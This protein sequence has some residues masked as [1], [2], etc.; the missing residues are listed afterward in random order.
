MTPTNMDEA[1]ASI[2]SI[3]NTTSNVLQTASAL[4]GTTDPFLSD[5]TAP[6]EPSGHETALEKE[7]AGVELEGGGSSTGQ[8]KE[9]SETA[10]VLDE[11]PSSPP[12]ASHDALKETLHDAAEGEG[13]PV[14]VDLTEWH[15]LD[16]TRSESKDP[17][18]TQETTFV[19][20]SVA[21]VSD[22]KHVLT[23]APRGQTSNPNLRIVTKAPSP[24]PWDLVD[25]P[26]SNNGDATDYYSTVG[27]KNFGTL[28][29]KTYALPQ[30]LILQC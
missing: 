12:P 22:E 14:E 6:Q 24:Q 16:H 29:K 3:P 30:L 26:P 10:L 25:P 18:Q 8:A 9:A 23:P 7:G 17:N 28:Q 27:T 13:E 11:L 21:H 5:E 15:P 19:E 2:S 20:D 4:S 1:E